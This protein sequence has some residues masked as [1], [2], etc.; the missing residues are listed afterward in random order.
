MTHAIREQRAARTLCFRPIAAAI[1]FGA[2][3]VLGGCDEVTEENYAK[4]HNDMTLQQVE[5][6]LGSGDEETSGGYGISSGGLMTGNTGEHDS[7]KTY[8]WKSGS[9]QII[10][11]F[12]GGKA[13]NVRKLGF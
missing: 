13:V 10:V 7:V 9:K 8:S 2:A 12:K 4:L 1:C 6:I 3:L 11:D 5:H